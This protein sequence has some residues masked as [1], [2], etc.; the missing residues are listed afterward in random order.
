MTITRLI[1]LSLHG[2]FE[3]ALG[4]GAMVAAL[5]LGL[6]PAGTVIGFGFGAVLMGLALATTDR[7]LVIATHRSL[8]SGISIGVLAGAVALAAV[9]Q[10][11]DAVFLAALAALHLVLGAVTRYSER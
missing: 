5:L 7:N 11:T 9:G 2:F 3:L 4:L 6:S 1:P 8:D 10:G